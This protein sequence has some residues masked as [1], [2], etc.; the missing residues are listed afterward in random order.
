MCRLLKLGNFSSVLKS[1][2]KIYGMKKVH[3]YSPPRNLAFFTQNN[4]LA[5]FKQL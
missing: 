5:T 2:R 3:E 1:F 4:A